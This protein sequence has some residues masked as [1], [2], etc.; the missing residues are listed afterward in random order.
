MTILRHAPTAATS[1]KREGDRRRELLRRYRDVRALSESICDG[2]EVEDFVVQSMPD[3]SPLKWHLAHT[4]WFF[5]TFLLV[6]HL[7][8]YERA[9]PVFNFL[10]NSYYNAVGPQFERPLRGLLSRP[11]VRDVMEY[12]TQVDERM[13]ELIDGLD[14]ERPASIRS[15][16]EIGLNHEQ[17]HQELMLTDVK[18]LFWQNPLRPACQNMQALP[19]AMGK[20]GLPV[21]DGQRH[22][23]TPFAHGTR[24][25]SFTEGQYEIGHDAA[26]HPD[27][28]A[29][30]NESP[31]HTVYLQPFAIA[32]RLITCSE[33][34]EFMEAGGY[35][36]PELWLSEGFTAARTEKWIAPLYWEKRDGDWMQFTLS[37]MRAIDPDEP[38]CHVSFFEADAYAR[39]REA[40]LP[41]EVEWEVAAARV[42][43]EGNFV[44]SGLNHPRPLDSLDDRFELAQMFGDVWEWTGSQ[45]RPY[46]G[47]RPPSGALGEYNGKFM[48]NQ[49]VL[50]GG[51]CATPQSH[52]RST[53][54]NFFPPAARWQFSGIRLA[55]DGGKV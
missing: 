37:G 34:L 33:Y 8:G 45:Y 7:A 21:A 52:I 53:Y 15:V 49:F 28:F 32:S 43:V 13:E 39:W 22:G 24:W 11:T 46:P 51:S 16:I 20:P 25:V 19:G 4:T 23:Q 12:R 31:R 38:A 44:E 35:E 18:H 3:A 36:R 40:R 5:E 42:P 55:R 10:F 6:D 47:Y 9:Q 27:A 1:G 48:C 2:L 14:V 17:Q 29:Y 26:A 41:T 54:R 50:R 30:D